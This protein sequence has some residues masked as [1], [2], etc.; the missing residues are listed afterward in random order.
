M[1]S[2]LSVFDLAIVFVVA[3][4]LVLISLRVYYDTFGKLRC[5][6]AVLKEANQQL[7]T[8][9]TELHKDNCELRILIHELNTRL[10]MVETRVSILTGRY[11]PEE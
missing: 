8:K 3:L 5:E 9:N 11:G 2:H 10:T 4:A 6:N 1:L 7:D